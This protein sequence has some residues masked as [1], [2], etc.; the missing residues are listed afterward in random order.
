MDLGFSVNKGPLSQINLSI[1]SFDAAVHLATGAYGW[2]KARSRSQLLTEV[3]E[4]A[5]G[6]LSASTT[7]NRNIYEM[8]RLQKPHAGHCL[9]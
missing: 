6:Q 5:H 4:S 8:V 3:L 7:F 2:W 9:Q 1:I